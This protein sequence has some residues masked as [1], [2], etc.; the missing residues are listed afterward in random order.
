MPIIAGSGQRLRF[1]EY[2]GTEHNVT[3]QATWQDWDLSSIVPAGTKFVQIRIVPETST[4]VA[5]GV[6]KNGSADVRT[7]NSPADTGDSVFQVVECDDNKVIECYVNSA[8]YK[9]YGFYLTGYWYEE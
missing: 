8:G 7:I 2:W 4:V 6:R 3:A 9:S 5:V 1:A